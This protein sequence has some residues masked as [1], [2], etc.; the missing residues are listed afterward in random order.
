[1]SLLAHGDGAAGAQALNAAVLGIWV[2]VFIVWRLL[3]RRPRTH[4]F[5]WPVTA[6]AAWMSLAAGLIH[7]VVVPEHWQESP[8]YGG[9]FVAATAAQLGLAV[10]LAQRSPAWL[11]LGNVAVQLG[12]VGL[13]AVTRT[14]GIPLGPEQGMVESVGVLDSLCVAAQVLSAA[15]C[16][17]LLRYGGLQQL[18]SVR[19]G[20]SV[21][22]VSG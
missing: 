12:L 9:F 4:G 1:M 6:V 8:L 15:A 21:V 3:D 2:P 22:A 18:S 17:V 20:T 13:W 5:A 11:L 7:L 19:R 14:A 10:L 16:A